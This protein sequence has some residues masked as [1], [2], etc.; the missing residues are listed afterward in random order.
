IDSD[1]KQQQLFLGPDGGSMK[2]VSGAQFVQVIS[3]E[4]PLGRAM[5][6]KCEGDEVSIQV[7]PI[8]QRFEV[9][10]VH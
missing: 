6:G 4:S 5:L 8:R 9:L 2:L 10:R 7:E 3:S 1:D